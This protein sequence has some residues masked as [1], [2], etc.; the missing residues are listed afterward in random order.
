MKEEKRGGTERERMK[1]EKGGS[2]EGERME[3][4]KEANR[5]KREEVKR[6]REKK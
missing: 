4:D 2:K 1:E 3:E 5:N 6:E